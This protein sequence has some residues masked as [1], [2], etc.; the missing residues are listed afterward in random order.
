[1][2]GKTAVK[3]LKV[4]FKTEEPETQTTKQEQQVLRKYAAGTKKAAEI[5]VFQGVNTLQI[6]S[7]MTPDGLLYGVDPFFK[8]KLGISWIELIAKAVIAPVKKKVVLVKK[9]S[10]DAA[11]EIPDD[12]DFIFI[13]GD[14]S[15]KGIEQDWNIYSAKLKPGGIMALHDTSVP[16]FD[17]QR[18]SLGSIAFYND[19]ISKDARFSHLERID[20]LNVL[21][22]NA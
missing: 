5:G 14:H 13:D 15:Y 9:L 1:M 18:A 19:V 6:A 20:S 11:T 22:R 8:G 7:A 4:I 16:M 21:Q 12:L 2:L 10:W 3:L 17:P